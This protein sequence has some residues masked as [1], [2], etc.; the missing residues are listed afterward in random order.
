MSDFRKHL[1]RNLEN[2]EFAAE[3]EQ[4]HPEYE[5]IRAVIAARIECNMTQKELAEK[6]GIR[7]SNISR[8]ENGTA[9]PTIDTLARIATGMGKK[10]KIDFV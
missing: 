7:Q 1:Q 5:A 2:P 8:I 3:Y 9:S 6:T 10:L 4:L